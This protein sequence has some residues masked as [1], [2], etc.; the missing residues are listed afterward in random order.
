MRN[1]LLLCTFTMFCLGRICAQGKII[2]DRPLPI[3]AWAGIPES[4][5]SV[6]RFTELRE[7]GINVNLSNYPSADAM[8][9]ALDLAHLVGI[10]MIASCPELKTDPEK[11]V[12]RF[13]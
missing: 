4:E 12:R 13:V 2:S 5:T 3:I 7:M 11:T 1:I 8:Q 6:E 9:N 10:K